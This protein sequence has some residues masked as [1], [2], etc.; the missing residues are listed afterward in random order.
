MLPADSYQEP[1]LSDEILAARAGVGARSAFATLVERYQDRVY[2]L[3][4][5]MSRNSSDA[6][7]IAQEAFFLAH[8]GIASFRGE[9]R[10]STWLY[11]ITVNQVLMRNRTARR[12]PAQSLD[13]LAWSGDVAPVGGEPPE[14]ADD[15]IHRKMLAHRVREALA[16]L[17]DSHRAAL[18]LRDLEE[19]SA[20]EAA[21]V[22][23][24][25]PDAVRQRA[26]RARL[27]LRQILGEVRDPR[28][29]VSAA[30]E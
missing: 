4:L 14:S 25:S 13:E 10:F 20:E 12:R 2:R 24:V 16:Q 11:R 26:H 28:P 1:A 5:R 3:A 17:D 6:E 8:R 27:K 18:V 9:S 30:A 7:E 29:I 15:L 21:E 19:M 23:G 22:L